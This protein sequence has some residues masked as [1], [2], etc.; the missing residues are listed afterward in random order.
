MVFRYPVQ[1]GDFADFLGIRSGSA[2]LVGDD[3]IKA[4]TTNAVLSHN[5][6]H[7]DT[8]HKV[9]TYTPAVRSEAEPR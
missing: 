7:N 4:G 6:V 5:A 1:A 3:S 8:G 9:D 2:D